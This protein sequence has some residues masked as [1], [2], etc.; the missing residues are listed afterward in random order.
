MLELLR[1]SGSRR[2]RI[3]R[4]VYLHS[5]VSAPPAAVGLLGSVAQGGAAGFG[6]SAWLPGITV[7]HLAPPWQTQRIDQIGFVGQMAPSRHAWRK[8]LLQRGAK[9]GI[10]LCAG[11]SARAQTA[12][13]YAQSPVSFNASLSGDLNMR[14]FEVLSAGG[15]LLT[16]RLS[17]QA[18][19]E[20]LLRPGHDCETYGY[21]EEL[22]DKIAFY[23]RSPAAALRIA[24]RV[25]R[26]I[27][28]S[29]WP[30]I[31]SGCCT[32]G[33]WTVD[34]LTC[35]I[36]AMTC[37][38]R[39]A[40]RRL[41]SLNSGSRSTRCSRSFSN[42]NQVCPCWS[43][44][45]VA[46]GICHGAGGPDARPG[47]SHRTHA[48]FC[49]ASAAASV[50][51]QLAFIHADAAASQCWDIV[52]TASADAADEPWRRRA[53]VVCRI[54]GRRQ[55]RLNCCK[56][57]PQSGPQCAAPAGGGWSMV[58]ALRWVE[59]S[60]IHHIPPVP[61]RATAAAASMMEMPA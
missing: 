35:S 6:Q 28:R 43:R 58:H 11:Q 53:G 59:R 20:L 3:E 38:L 15:F 55:W 25:R 8:A 44:R 46:A 42:S 13:M 23:R 56:N 2:D 50:L 33:C 52:L 57:P 32:S 9:A 60:E 30:S 45:D 39:R 40:R 61:T 34:C 36:R 29:I 37:G 26:L 12:A 5:R 31:G 7:Q 14:V 47:N 51:G 16:D 24:S 18:G 17:P 41:D 22:L 10:P 48:G 19:L 49:A 21:A 4:G 54:R 1:P 27:A